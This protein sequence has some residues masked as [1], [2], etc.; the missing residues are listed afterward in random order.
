MV[1]MHSIASV[2]WKAKRDFYKICTPLSQPFVIKQIV[3]QMASKHW[4]NE[5]LVIH[6]HPLSPPAVASISVTSTSL[7]VIHTKLS[8]SFLEATN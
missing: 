3:K 6:W 1:K 8:L 7:Q 4:D 2:F 5:V